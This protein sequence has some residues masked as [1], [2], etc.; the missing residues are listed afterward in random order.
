MLRIGICDNESAARESLRLTCERILHETVEETLFYAFSSGEGVLHWLENHPDELDILFLDIEMNG[1]SGMETARRIREQDDRLVLV[2]VTGFADYV[3]DGYAVNALDYVLKPCRDPR[4]REVLHRAQGQLHRLAPETFTI[5][6]A[7]GL[8]RIAKAHIRYL[9]SERRTVT[10]VTDTRTYTY[11]GRL[12][13]AEAELGEGFVRLHQR[14]LARIQAI[15]RITG[16]SA[17]IQGTAL[18]IS[19]ANRQRALLIF[20]RSMLEG[21]RA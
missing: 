10:L 9:M 6:N 1:I 7:D 15:E 3:F 13:D 19:R 14:Y 8:F 12:D 20:A 17:Y 16:S 11:Y 2:F 18:P 4:L 5:K 21:R